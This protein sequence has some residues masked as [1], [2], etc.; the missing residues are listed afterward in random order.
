MSGKHSYFE[1]SLWKAAEDF[2][3]TFVLNSPNICSTNYPTFC[4]NLPTFGLSFLNKKRRKRCS[5]FNLAL[6]KKCQKIN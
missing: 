3:R 2:R 1:I 4:L 5:S 6:I